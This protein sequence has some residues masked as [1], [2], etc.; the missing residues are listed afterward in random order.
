MERGWGEAADPGDVNPLAP[1][2]CAT[3][4]EGLWLLVQPIDGVVVTSGVCAA[5]LHPGP[6]LNF[7]FG[8]AGAQLF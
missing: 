4:M 3:G 7:P 1:I 2:P 6:G 8:A 5:A